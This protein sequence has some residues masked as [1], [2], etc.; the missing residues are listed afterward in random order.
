MTNTTATTN[1][2]D[3]YEVTKGIAHRPYGKSIVSE[4]ILTGKRGAIYTT[5]RSEDG[6]TFQFRDK[7]GK[8]VAI[9]GNYRLP[10]AKVA[11][12]V[13]EFTDADRIA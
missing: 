5:W 11:S 1:L 2:F 4:F 9:C 6:N 7:N 10:V 8:F 3:K 12:H 13:I